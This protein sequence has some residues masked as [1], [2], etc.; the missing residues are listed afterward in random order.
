ME[1][2]LIQWQE[3]ELTRNGPLLQAR[4][5]DGGAAALDVLLFLRPAPAA[6]LRVPGVAG[7]QPVRPPHLPAAAPGVPAQRLFQ[8][9]LCPHHR[10]ADAR[11]RW[12]GM[13]WWRRC[14]RASSSAKR[15][16]AATA[17]IRSTRPLWVMW[18]PRSPGRSRCSGIRSLT[19]ASRSGMPPAWPCPAPSRTPCAAAAPSTSA[20]FPWGWAR[21]AA[22]MGTGAALV[23]VLQVERSRIG[24]TLAIRN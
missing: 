10:P 16:S 15:C 2:A 22:P 20:P 4:L 21:Y 24:L 17:A 9:E 11:Q 12:T 7:G 1:E 5:L 23:L 18:W 13:F 19:R 8:R 3:Q 6:A 14:W